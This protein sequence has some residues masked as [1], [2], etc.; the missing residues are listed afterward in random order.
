MTQPNQSQHARTFFT[1]ADG[2]TD[3]IVLLEWCEQSRRV[4]HAGALELGICASELEARLRNASRGPVGGL[5]ARARSRQVAKPIQQAS[6]ALVIASRYII[7][8]STRFQAVFMPELE[9]VGHRPRRDQFR[10]KAS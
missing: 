3:N 1:A 9:Q 6:E 5:S 2:I 7:T 10:F 8:A 4:L